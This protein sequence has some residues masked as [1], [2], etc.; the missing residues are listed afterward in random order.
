MFY[1]LISVLALR[2]FSLLITNIVL[3]CMKVKRQGVEGESNA[4]TIT[5]PRHMPE[6]SLSQAY[7]LMDCTNIKV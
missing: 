4:I 2:F 3:Y 5:S 1:P 6:I 7:T